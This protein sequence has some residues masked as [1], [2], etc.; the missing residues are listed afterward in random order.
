[1]AGRPADQAHLE[2][3]GQRLEFRGHRSA[4]AR[5][6]TAFT[7]GPASMVKNTSVPAARSS[8]TRSIQATEAGSSM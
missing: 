7:W 6:H 2:H 5:A 1:M 8:R 3:T 4:S